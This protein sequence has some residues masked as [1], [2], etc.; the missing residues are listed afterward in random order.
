MRASKD[1]AL[2]SHTSHSDVSGSRWA[3]IPSE[4]KSSAAANSKRLIVCG[5][6]V[7]ISDAGGHDWTD[8]FPAIAADA[9]NNLRGSERLFLDVCTLYIIVRSL[10]RERM[11]DERGSLRVVLIAMFVVAAFIVAIYAAQ[12]ASLLPMM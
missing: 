12:H 6:G 4:A 2:P 3:P 7:R 11:M 1:A 8:R 9:R 5:P 10:H